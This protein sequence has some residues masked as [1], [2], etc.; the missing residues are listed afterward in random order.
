[1]FV[2]RPFDPAWHAPHT[3]AAG[4]RCSWHGVRTCDKRAVVS[5]HDASGDRQSACERAV[6]ELLARGLMKR[7]PDY[8]LWHRHMTGR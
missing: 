2:T 3:V 4:G 1:M 6:A 7:P 8:D 5:F